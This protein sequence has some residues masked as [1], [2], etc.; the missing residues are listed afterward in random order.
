VDIALDSDNKPRIVGMDG[1]DGLGK[2]VRE[3]FRIPFFRYQR[4]KESGLRVIDD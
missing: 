3:G 4:G 1:L 2:L